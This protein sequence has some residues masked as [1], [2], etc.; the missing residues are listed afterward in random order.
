M[1]TFTACRSKP[2]VVVPARATPQEVKQLSDVDNQRDLRLYVTFIEFYRRRVEGVP[3]PSAA[4]SIIKAALSEALV[5]YYPVAGRLRELP[6]GDKLAVDCTAEGVVFVEAHAD[7]RLEEF[8]TPLVPPYP[9]V[10]ELICQVGDLRAVVGKPLLYLQITEFRCGGF[11]L[12]LTMCHN[13]VDAFGKMQ[14]LKCIVDLARGQAAPSVLPS[15]ERHL[16]VSSAEAASES[17]QVQNDAK[18][19]PAQTPLMI[20]EEMV[21]RTFLFGPR[22]IAALRASLPA[23]LAQSATVF[24]LI[25]AAVWR[26]RTAALEHAPD[27]RVF[28]LFFTNARGSWKRDPPLPAGFYGN[29]VFNT[30]A[31][32]AVGKLCGGPLTY[33]VQLVH[34]AKIRMTDEYVRSMLAVLARGE[35]YVNVA[36]DKTFIVTDVSRSGNNLMDLGWAERV[37]GGGSMA[38][39][40]VNRLA[41]AYMSCKNANG[42]ECVMMPISLPELAMERFAS[43]LTAVTKD[44][45]RSSL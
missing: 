24:E 27:E 18:S 37:G 25:T 15:W 26:C 3:E 7:V 23:R 8:G 4:S 21:T 42:E 14:L 20:L 41:S 45:A 44:L 32:A 2:E 10:D 30:T 35:R 19:P 31:E 22:E 13:I 28:V 39:D 9:C 33:A 11:A 6:G 40:I 16:L 12:A 38:G 17:Y 43:Q 5:Y 36:L 29:A 1:V 34:E